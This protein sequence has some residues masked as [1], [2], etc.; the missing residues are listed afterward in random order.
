MTLSPVGARERAAG[1]TDPPR[2]VTA[3]ASVDRPGRV[4]VALVAGCLVQG[5]AEKQLVYTARALQTVGAEVRVFSLT[6]GQYYEP[7]LRELGLEPCWIGRYAHP[8]LRVGV[9]A[10]QLWRFR[11]HVI[12]SNLFFTNLYAALAG[13]VCGALTIG[14]S[15]SD[16]TY[17]MKDTGAWAP[18]LLRLPATLVTN[19]HA[20]KRNAEALGL[21]PAAVCVLPNAIDLT[22]F[23]ARLNPGGRATRVGPPTAITVGWLI[24]AKRYDRFLEALAL[25]RRTVPEMR[26]VLVGDGPERVPLERQ[27]DALGLLPHA[28][29]FLGHQ[30]NVPALLA[31]SDLLVSCS[32]HE[33]LPNVIL[34]GMAARLPVVTTPAGDCGLVVEDGRT[35][36]VVPFDDV[37]GLAE[38]M[39]RLARA[40]GLRRQFGEAGRQRVEEEYSLDGLA[41]RLLAIY[42]ALGQQQ[43][44]HELLRRLPT[45]C[46]RAN[47]SATLTTTAGPDARTGSPGRRREWSLA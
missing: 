24:R 34:E 44:K 10:A 43:Q 3:H 4:R 13:R 27:A 36:Y 11:P 14:A 1:R 22:D 18:W 7:V 35:G 28:V 30:S 17:E 2:G 45:E 12:Q 20:A 37:E 16:L 15:Q 39:V 8:L 19:T 26:G 38:R 46:P 9:L 47:G 6:R 32:D 33:G 21:D 42:R 31:D 25:A 23:D 5:G 40:P 41:G 29:R